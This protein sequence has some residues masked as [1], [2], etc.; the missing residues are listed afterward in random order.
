MFLLAG[1]AKGPCRLQG[2]WN[3][4]CFIDSLATAKAEPPVKPDSAH[5]LSG[6][7]QKPGTQTGASKAVQGFQEQGS[8]QASLAMRVQDTKVLD[9]TQTVFLADSL[10][11]SAITNRAGD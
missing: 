1:S 9:G 8:T 11:R 6:Y 4:H 2:A 10:H 5:V 3:L 7:F